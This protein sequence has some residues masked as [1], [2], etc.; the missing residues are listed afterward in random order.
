MTDIAIIGAGRLGTCLGAALAKAGYRIS[1][2]T[3]K[4]LE[5][6][7]ESRKI[8]GQG[9]AGTN[10][11]R[12]AKMGEIIILTVP[13]D[14]IEKAA[15][16]MA[17]PSLPWADKQVFHC[18]GLHSSH[19]LKS[20]EKLGAITASFHPVQTFPRKS[21]KA[22]LFKN[23]YVSLEGDPRAIKTAEIMITKIGGRPFPIKATDKPIYHS[24]CSIASNL[25]VIFL[26]IAID[27]VKR[28][29]LSEEQ[30]FGILF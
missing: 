27:L 17:D 15:N 4:T 2:L 11:R 8:I 6:A 21:A 7:E 9:E 25:L 23:I 28:T 26:D 22:G 12:A 24:A 5:E 18:S 29:G 20:L 13:D 10:N 3:A 14:L 19:I 1:S 30:S 16:E